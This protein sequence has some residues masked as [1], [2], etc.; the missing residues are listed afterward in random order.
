MK[1][2]LRG[3]HIALSENKTKQKQKTNKQTKTNLESTYQQLDSTPKRSR[4]KGSNFTQEEQM[5]GNNQTQGCN[6][7]SRHK[8]NYTESTKPGAGSLRKS[9]RQINSQPG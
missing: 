2:T 4:T 6:Q 9:T 5:A 7:P 1:A 8:K 3:K